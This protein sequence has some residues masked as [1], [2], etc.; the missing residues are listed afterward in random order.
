MNSL[1]EGEELLMEKNEA[2]D[3]IDYGIGKF[4]AEAG[5]TV[6]DLTPLFDVSSYP[7]EQRDLIKNC[8]D[9]RGYVRQGIKGRYVFLYFR[10]Q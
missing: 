10:P 3:S 8:Q 1:L 5:I 4:A 7:E 9:Q 6:D 2:A